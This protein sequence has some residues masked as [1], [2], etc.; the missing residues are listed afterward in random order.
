[1]L[2]MIEFMVYVKIRIKIVL[3]IDFVLIYKVFVILVVGSFWCNMV[4]KVIVRLINLLYINEV[5][6]LVFL[7]VL[8][9]LNDWLFFVNVFVLV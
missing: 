5:L 9:I 2:L 3:N 4:I 1:M 7:N 6:I 8:K